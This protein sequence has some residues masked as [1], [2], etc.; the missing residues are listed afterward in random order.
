MAVVDSSLQDRIDFLKQVDLFSTLDHEELEIVAFHSQAVQ[1]GEGS[2]VFTEQSPSQ[3]LFVVLDGEVLITRNRDNID[4]IDL[5]QFIPGESFGAWDMIGEV[6]RDATAIAMRSTILLLFPKEGMTFSMVLHRYPR[7]SARILYKLL[8][9]IG[10]RIR[11]THELITEKTPWIED[12]K[13]LVNVD[14]LTGLFNKNYLVEDLTKQ[15][16]S[17]GSMTSILMIKPDNFKDLND[18]H[19]HEAGDKILILLAIF[20]QSIMREKDIALRYHGDEFAVL[21]PATGREE[22]IIL[23]R[24]LGKTVY[25]IDLTG[26]T[27]GNVKGMTVSIGVAVYPEHTSDPKELAKIAY[28]TMFKARNRGGNRIVCILDKTHAISV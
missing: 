22:A 27:G 18:S 23:A 3:E 20:M 19:G 21:L 1:Y 15:I 7:V 28:D 8:S 24:E 11:R 5:A 9:I 10:S 4:T 25:D 14:K 13:R 16:P 6:P 26:I 12:V 17:M 2:V